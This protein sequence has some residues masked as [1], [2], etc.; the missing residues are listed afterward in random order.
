FYDI[1]HESS[2]GLMCSWKPDSKSRSRTVHNNL[3][4]L[5]EGLCVI[6]NQT[7]RAGHGRYTITSR[8]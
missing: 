3:T 4:S 5:V 1:P 2:G 8:V 6:G 7:L